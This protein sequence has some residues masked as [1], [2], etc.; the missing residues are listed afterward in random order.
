M[1]GNQWQVSGDTNRIPNGQVF[2]C[3]RSQVARH[4]FAFTLVELLVVIAIIGVLAALLLPAL[5]RGKEAARSTAC[6]SNLH[7]IGLA[8]QIYV[9][10]HNNRLPVMRDRSADT[11][12]PPTNALPSADVVLKTELGNL[13]VLCCPSDRNGIFEQTGS[14][15]SWN[16]LLNG[17]DA[18]HLKVL[19]LN[20]S[21]RAIPVFFDKEGFHAARGPDKAVNYLYA[22]GHIKNL[23]T[24]EGS[25]P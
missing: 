23:L 18:D 21:P 13:K 25:L 10:N 6:V 3:H 24:I 19:G 16:S 9:N 17:E 5:S 7:Q 14:S 4:P 2:S 22:D 11:N 20:F 12:S 8:L 1:K 15:Y